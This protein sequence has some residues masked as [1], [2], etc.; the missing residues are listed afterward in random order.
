MK[1]GKALILPAIGSGMS[2]PLD[3]KKP[4]LGRRLKTVK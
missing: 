2:K 1:R 4:S 3:T